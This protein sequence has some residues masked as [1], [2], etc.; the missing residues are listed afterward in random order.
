M[1][2][3]LSVIVLVI[4]L[5]FLSA[6][7]GAQADNSASEAPAEAVEVAAAEEDAQKEEDGPLYIDPGGEFTPIFS[8]EGT[9]EQ[10]TNRAMQNFFDDLE[11]V[12]GGKFKVQCYYGATLYKHE[13]TGPAVKAN[14]IQFA[15]ASCDY[16]VDVSPWIGQ[17]DSAYFYADRDHCARFWGSEDAQKW[18]DRFLEETGVRILSYEVLGTR[19][20]WFR[21]MPIEDV[22]RNPEEMKGINL[23]AAGSPVMMAMKNGMGANAVPISVSE[24]MSSILTGAIDGMGMPANTGLTLKYYDVAKYLCLTDHGHNV[25]F[26]VVNE[27]FFQQLTPEFQEYMIQSADKW[28]R[29]ADNE[30]SKEIETA[31]KELEEKGVIIIDDMDKDAFKASCEAYITEQTDLEENWD[32]QFYADVQKYR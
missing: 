31:L 29:W 13:A 26:P 9:P 15:S 22:P 6:C 32:P 20:L 3:K 11:Q 12:S 2:K 10:A 30:T 14:E 24:A 4:L 28:M 18:M 19:E 16:L 5:A 1:K 8:V 21:D 25:L 23:R 27:E 7:T 17:S